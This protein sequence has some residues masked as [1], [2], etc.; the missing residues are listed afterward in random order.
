MLSNLFMRVLIIEDDPILLK[1]Y[2]EKFENSGYEVSTAIE[3]RE[4]VTKALN[5]Q[6]D[7]IILDLMMPKM[8]GIQVLK[9]LKSGSKTRDIPVGILSVIPKEQAPGLTEELIREI[10]EYWPKDRVN[11]SDVVTGVGNYFKGKNG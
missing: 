2:R 9:E 10:V 1:M 8:D 11:P 5:D 6:P 7:F 3:G 4:G